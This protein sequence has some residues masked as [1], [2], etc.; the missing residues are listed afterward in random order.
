MKVMQGACLRIT[1]TPAQWTALW[2]AFGQRP[3]GH[4]VAM[5][6]DKNFNDV[7]VC[8]AYQR[9]GEPTPDETAR[10]A[11]KEHEDDSQDPA[12]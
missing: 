6:D 1:W 7:D 3:R 12:V 4:C 11:R 10:P 8:V 5:I 2:F 9:F